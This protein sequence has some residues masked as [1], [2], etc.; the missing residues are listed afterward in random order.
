MTFA[1]LGVYVGVLCEFLKKHNIMG[2]LC[3]VM[4]M[5]WWCEI[6]LGKSVTKVYD[7]TL[8]ALRGGG[9]G[10]KFQEKCIT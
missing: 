7:S 3:Y 10:S 5:G 4:Q 6:F 1:G 2:P 9:R 8:L